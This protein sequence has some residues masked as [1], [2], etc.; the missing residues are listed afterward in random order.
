MHP[1]SSVVQLLV[2]STCA[3]SR[4]SN[5]DESQNFTIITNFKFNTPPMTSRC[6]I[7]VSRSESTIIRRSTLVPLLTS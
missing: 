1:L 2:I 3:D 4:S 5:P 6:V 7:G